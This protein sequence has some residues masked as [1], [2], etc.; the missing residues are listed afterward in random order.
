MS[1]KIDLVKIEPIEYRP[2]DKYPRIIWYR[3][4]SFDKDLTQRKL[5]IIK[6]KLILQRN[7]SISC[8]PNQFLMWQYEGGPMIILDLKEGTINTTKGTVEHF[9]IGTCQQAAS[10]LLRI[11]RK[12]RHAK[13]KQVGIS[14]YRIGET[15]QRRKELLETFERLKSIPKEEE[16]AGW[17]D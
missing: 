1:D 11:L 17:I 4:L 9:G 5:D 3:N 15:P 13:F 7:I 14:T 6:K 2:S 10:T 12:Y 16:I 8:N